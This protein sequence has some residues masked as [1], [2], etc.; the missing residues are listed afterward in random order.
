MQPDQTPA[1]SVIIP[2]RDDPLVF[3]AVRAVLDQQGLPAS[4]EV[5]VVDNGSR[6]AFRRA[7]ARLDRQVIVLDEP[8]Q[9]AA[10]A[11]NRGIGHARGEFIFFTD[12]D[13]TPAPDWIVEG[14]RGFDA[15]GADILS[16]GR[17][18]KA[19]SRNQRLVSAANGYRASRRR[20]GAG[21]GGTAGGPGRRHDTTP[22][23]DTANAAVRRSVFERVRFDVALLRGQD[24]AFGDEAVAA[25]FVL[26]DWPAM[27]VVIRPDEYLRLRVAKEIMGGWGYAE[28]AIRRAAAQ[29]RPVRP[30]VAARRLGRLPGVATVFP[31]CL[32]PCIAAAGV[33]DCLARLLPLR[34][35]VGPAARLTAI[36][37]RAGRVGRHL[38]MPPLSP[39]DLARGRVRVATGHL[40]RAGGVT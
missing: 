26:R 21:A 12:A 9:G 15:T 37:R 34:W 10:A 23:A 3:Q 27:Q 11:R 25:G 17:L 38:G 19:T 20:S 24:L 8:L 13:C 22:F 33:I 32:L 28:R 6:Q 18:W 7:L 36:G 30:P 39:A 2:V 1:V 35:L 14:L 40:P 5:I 29:G 31:A 16:G 4:P